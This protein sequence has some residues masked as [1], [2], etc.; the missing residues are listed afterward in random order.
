MLEPILGPGIGPL[1]VN[2]SVI[3]KTC[4]GILFGSY[5]TLIAVYI[6]TRLVWEAPRWEHSGDQDIE[7]LETLHL[8][9][10]LKSFNACFGCLSIAF[11]LFPKHFQNGMKNVSCCT[12][13]ASNMLYRIFRILDL[14]L[15]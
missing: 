9:K 10:P 1:L 3:F 14:Y 13:R 8:Q 12:L 15:G 5:L 7:R 4:I 11:K 6:E 2:L